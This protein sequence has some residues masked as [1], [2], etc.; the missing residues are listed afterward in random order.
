MLNNYREELKHAKIPP[1]KAPVKLGTVKISVVETTPLVW[2]DRLIRFEWVR[3]STWGGPGGVDRKIGCYQFVDMETEEGLGEFALDHAFG[4]AYTEN[5]KMFVHGVRGGGGGNVIDTFISD[6][7]KSWESS[8][9]LVFP[10]NIKLF[11]T[12]VCKAGDKYVMAIEVGGNDPMVGVGFTCVFAESPDLI[13]WTL[14]DHEKF[15]YSKDRYTACPCIRYY[16]GYYYI[17]CLERAPFHRW[18]PYIARSRDLADYELGVINPFMWFDND[19]KKVIRP[20]RFTEDELDYIANAVNCNCSDIDMCN[21]GDK[22]VITYS[23]GNQLGKEFLAIAEYDG[24]EEELLKSF[25]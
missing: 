4:C 13:N 25:F 12:S 5:G 11:N 10:E 17:I 8:T 19:D 18:I 21:Y 23:W 6:D 24:S 15:S 2:N 9:A 16:D 7:L 22:T 3:N 20:E 14:L 1:R